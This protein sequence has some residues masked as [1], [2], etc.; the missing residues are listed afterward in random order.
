MIN[1]D[2]LWQTTK[3]MAA[4][5]TEAHRLERNR[6]AYS[7]IPMPETHD[8]LCNE[9]DDTQYLAHARCQAPWQFPT[10]RGVRTVTLRS[11]TYKGNDYR[12]YAAEF[13]RILYAAARHYALSNEKEKST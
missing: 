13:D 7:Y 12:G 8:E 3:E 10:H 9:A 4:T 1:D 11:L 2:L 5:W 6:I